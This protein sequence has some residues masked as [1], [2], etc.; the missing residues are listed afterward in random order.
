VNQ[1][2][3]K[4]GFSP[5]GGCFAAASEYGLAK[6]WETTTLREVASLHGFL[7]GVHSV[8]FSP[9]GRRLA[10]GSGGKEAIKL[11]DAETHQEVLTLE[12]RGSL[13]GRQGPTA[14]SPDGNV[15]GS[16]NGNG[17]LHLWRAP[18]W[19]EIDAAEKAQAE[20]ALP[21]RSR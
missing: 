19:A 8:A 20:A 14:F 6:I 9:D 21:P 2:V 17:I 4:P 1:V 10:T 11:W 15:L 16:A 3:A 5:D 18:S 12:G 13:F 7:S